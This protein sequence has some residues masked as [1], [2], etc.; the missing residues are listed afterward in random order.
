MLAGGVEAPRRQS[1][2]ERKRRA[3]AMPTHG[4]S[5]SSPVRAERAPAEEYIL[6]LCKC[7]Q[8]TRGFGVPSG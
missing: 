1:G 5:P 6:V 4:V 3:P 8:S 7:M 2:G